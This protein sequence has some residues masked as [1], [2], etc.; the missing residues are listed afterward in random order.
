VGFREHPLQVLLFRWF[1]GLGI[2]DPPGPRRHP[3]MPTFLPAL[4]SN[5]LTGIAVAA[6]PVPERPR[7]ERHY[8]R[9]LAVVLGT[10]V[11]PEWLSADESTLARIQHDLIIELL[12]G[13]ASAGPGS[14]R[15]SDAPADRAARYELT[16]IPDRE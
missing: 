3:H 4:A 16:P 5:R 7:S 8:S 13:L 1:V 14:Q 9:R 12:G 6:S 10:I 11:S 15:R 2:D